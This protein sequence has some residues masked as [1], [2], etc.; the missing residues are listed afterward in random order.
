MTQVTVATSV[1]ISLSSVGIVM[2]TIEMSSRDIA[3][4]IIITP[5]MRH[6]LRVEELGRRVGAGLG[7]LCHLTE[8]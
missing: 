4:P 3:Q 5:K 8:R 7:R 1:D 6:L 2:F